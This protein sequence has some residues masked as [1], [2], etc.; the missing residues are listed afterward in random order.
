MSQDLYS[1]SSS[2]SFTHMI[3]DLQQGDQ[4]S[5]SDLWRFLRER[6]LD[7]SRKANRGADSPVNDDEDTVALSSADTLDCWQ[8]QRDNDIE[9]REELWRQMAFIAFNKARSRA[10]DETRLQDAGG[11]SFEPGEKMFDAV[12]G[13]TPE[14]NWS[15]LMQEGCA[16][17]LNQLQTKELRNVALL[18]VQGYTNE[19]IANQIGCTRRAIQRRLVLIREI[20][21][22]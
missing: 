6:L 22:K 7:L 9:C 4:D 13:E 19:A 14:A 20:W 21:S 11:T 17:L 1:D 15:M 2:V 5:A 10:T 8:E 3:A 18:N 16:E 12:S